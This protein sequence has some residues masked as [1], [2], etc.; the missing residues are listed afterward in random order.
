M[1]IGLFGGTFNPPH[2]G[3][4]RLALDFYDC[5]APDL[6]IV[7]PSFL[8]PHKA[9]AAVSPAV[10]LAMT[11]LACLALGERGVN[12]TV[13]DYEIVRGGKSFTIDTV[14]HLFAEYHVSELALCIGSD[15]LFSFESWKC[16]DELMHKCRLF[17]KERLPGERARLREFADKLTAR[18]GADITVMP[19]DAL[20]VS[21]TALREGE[22]ARDTLLDPRVRAF[23]EQNALYK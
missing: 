14:N 8:P 13:S 22:N 5:A 3:H 16:A 6:L 9:P 4:T 10:R 7:M 19:S 17:T 23:I 21:S 1:K 15:M 2:L 18:Y 11:R 20:E 12:Y